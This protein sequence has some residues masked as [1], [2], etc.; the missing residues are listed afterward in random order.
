MET[1][2][3]KTNRRNSN[4]VFVG[5]AW[6]NGANGEFVN[7][8]FDR[9]MEVVI[10]DKKNNVQYILPEGTSLFGYPNSKREGKKDADLRF[11]F[12]IEE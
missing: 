12:Q 6:L 1:K 4:R 2:T 10:T 3:A 11:S 7:L 5:K 8:S 9:G